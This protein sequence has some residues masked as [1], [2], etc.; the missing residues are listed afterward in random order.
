MAVKPKG[1]A[2]GVQ[3]WC[4]AKI[5]LIDGIRPQPRTMAFLFLIFFYIFFLLLLTHQHPYISP[6]FLE[7]TSWTGTG[8]VMVMGD[9]CNT[10]GISL[11]A[12]GW[13]SFG[14]DHGRYEGAKLVAPW[15]KGTNHSAGASGTKLESRCFSSSPCRRGEG[16]PIQAP[17]PPHLPTFGTGVYPFIPDGMF[18]CIPLGH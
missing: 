6:L 11:I 5:P 15:R 18:G 12:S 1:R 14:L 16:K 8:W 9:R 2:E 13:P 7:E 3:M 10:S 17:T 4:G